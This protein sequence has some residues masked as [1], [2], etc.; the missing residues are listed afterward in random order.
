MMIWTDFDGFDVD[1]C[2]SWYKYDVCSVDGAFIHRQGSVLIDCCVV[3]VSNFNIF[4]Y[5][6]K[7]RDNFDCYV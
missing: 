7:N 4:E 3:I 5:V 6:D 1:C 2:I